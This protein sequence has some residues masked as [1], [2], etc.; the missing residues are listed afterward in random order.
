MSQASFALRGRNPDVLACIA[1]LSNDEVFTPPELANQMLDLLA[2]AWAESHSGANIWAN[3]DLRF[4]DPCTKSGVFLREITRRLTQGLEEVIPNLES[5]VAHILSKQVFGIGLTKIT[6]MLARRSLYCSKHAQGKHSIAK[7]LS[8]DEGNVWFKRTEHEWQGDGCRYCGA[9]KLIFD[10]AGELESHAYAFIHSDDSKAEISAMFGGNMQFDV[11]IGNPPYQLANGESSDIPIYQLFVNQAKAL[12]PRFLCMVIPARWMA[13]GKWLD[14]FRAEMLGDVRIR[15]LVD[16]EMMSEVFPGVDFE[17]GACYFLWDKEYVGKTHVS[18]M[19]GGKL[20]S[21]G[22]RDLRAFDVFVRDITAAEILEKVLSFKERSI[23]EIVSGQ[24]PFGLHTNFSD[25]H[26]K[27][28][29]G[30]IAIHYSRP[31]KRALAYMSRNL[32]EKGTELVDSWKLLV[33]EAFGERGAKPARVLG[34]PVKAAPGEV[35]TQ[36]YLVI[37]PF[38][39]ENEVEN[40]ESYYNTRFFRFLVSLRKITQHA[41]RATYT[42]VPAQSWGKAWS[43]AELYAKY[44]FTKKEI[45]YIE[46]V[47]R[48]MSVGEVATHE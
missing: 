39:S 38:G 2:D 16:F 44:G 34:R 20:V 24:T 41:G 12:E 31:G 11:I 46:S 48:P 25:F 28:K 30:D 8:S 9:G 36:T 19:R 33:P 27:Q 22:E 5:R 18:T 21:A 35:C 43:D 47:I 45:E 23:L 40:F 14:D 4:L 17:G 10:R 7:S 42:W 37:G 13:G 29:N 32:I 15:N 1:N 26:D 6:S 3:K